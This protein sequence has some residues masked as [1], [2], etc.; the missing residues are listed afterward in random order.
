MKH[1]ERYGQGQDVGRSRPASS[2]EVV[3]PVGEEEHEGPDAVLDRDQPR[4]AT[5]EG[6]T[7]DGVDKGG[8]EEL[9][10]KRPG[11]ETEH[12]LLAVAY[13]VRL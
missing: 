1:E 8:P 3:D 10:A 13:F 4:F 7:V 12:G 11:H 5:P 9:Q 2:H 6:A